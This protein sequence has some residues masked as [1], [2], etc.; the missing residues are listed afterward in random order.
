MCV[1]YDNGVEVACHAMQAVFEDDNTEAVLLVDAENAFNSMNRKVALFNI[2][3]T[4][5]AIGPALINT[6]R[7][8]PKLF[9][10]GKTLISDEGTTQGDPLAMAMYALAVAPLMKKCA[11]EA[12]EVWFADDASAGGS[13][14]D[15]FTWWEK[16]IKYGPQFGYFPKACKS[17]VVVKRDSEAKAREVFGGTGLNITLEGSKHLG[18]PLGTTEFRNRCIDE[19][20]QEWCEKIEKLA[21]FARSQP[22]AAYSALTHGV[23]SSWMYF[24]R[25]VP[26]STEQLQ[27]LEI[28]ICEKLIPALT[29][30]QALTEYERDLFALPVRD[31]G[32]GIPITHQISSQQRSLSQRI[33]GPL[34]KAVINQQ[35]VLDTN[36][37]QEHAENKKEVIRQHLH[38]KSVISSRTVEH[39]PSKLQRQIAI[40]SQDGASSWLST[41]PLKVYDF[42]LHKRAFHDAVALRYGWPPDGVPTRCECGKPFSV[43]HALNCLKGAFPTLRHNEVRDLTASLLDEVC[44]DVCV[45]PHLQPLTGEVL[46]Y[47]TANRQEE[48]RSDI[49]A[50]GFW[51][52]RFEKV[53]MDVRVFNPNADSYRDLPPDACFKRH[54]QEKR[55]QYGQ[56]IRE[57]EHASFSPLVFSTSGGMGKSTTI[58]YKRLAHLLAVKRDEPYSTVICWMRCRLGFALTRSAIMCLRGCRSIHSNNAPPSISQCVVEGQIPS[59]D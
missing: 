6:Y 45:E 30:R 56:R 19:K 40:I 53:F 36:L 24:M 43:D 23:I 10:Q 26:L 16:L 42:A 11:S 39:L 9:I 35:R 28:A 27:P 2:L 50:C 57:V 34:V 15:T 31:G 7:S 38:E 44:H 47:R 17:F 55:R 48:A 20:V 51:G 29:G 3:H 32:M 5:P 54:E 41:I 18:I 1:G 58:V 33:C 37:L 8:Q 22:H 4:C 49:S 12:T 13:I 21:S 59:S 14:I 46:H 25:M 52:S